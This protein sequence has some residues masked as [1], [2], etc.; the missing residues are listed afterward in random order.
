MGDQSL[1]RWLLGDPPPLQHPRCRK[2]WS[3]YPSRPAEV[4]ISEIIRK[5]QTLEWVPFFDP[6]GSADDEPPAREIVDSPT[7]IYNGLYYQRAKNPLPMDDIQ[8]ALD[9]MGQDFGHSTA[10]SARHLYQQYNHWMALQQLY[11]DAGWGSGEASFD[12]DEFER[13]KLD[14]IK[15][16]GKLRDVMIEA[17]KCPPEVMAMLRADP[18]L[19][20]R[21]KEDYG[22]G[23][24]HLLT[25]GQRA[26]RE[27][28]GK[29]WSD[30]WEEKAGDQAMKYA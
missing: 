3:E 13:M 11:R 17:E 14:L 30:F 23:I 29:A 22:G 6:L 21:I 15:S 12:G 7:V 25:G 5:L 27:E 4:V 9:R 2:S 24:A 16:E 1:K 10:A 19:D 18:E 8:A 28:A 26:S 20:R